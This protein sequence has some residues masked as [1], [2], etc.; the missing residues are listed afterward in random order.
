MIKIEEHTRLLSF[1]ELE[2]EEM[3]QTVQMYFWTANNII[4]IEREE[5]TWL[6]LPIKQ[7]DQKAMRLPFAQKSIYCFGTVA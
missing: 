4:F 5:P 1:I 3:I 2:H 7:D 6:F